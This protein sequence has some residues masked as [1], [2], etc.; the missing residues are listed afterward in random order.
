MRSVVLGERGEVEGAGAQEGTEESGAQEGEV[1]RAAGVAA[2]F[3][4]LRA[5]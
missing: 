5:R 2:Q 3:G 4:N 1:A